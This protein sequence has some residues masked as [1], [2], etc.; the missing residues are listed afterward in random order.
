[1]KLVK[2]FGLLALVIA[3][4]ALAKDCDCALR[5]TQQVLRFTTRS[6]A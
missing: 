2:L 4:A 6:Q 5:G 1:M 3:L